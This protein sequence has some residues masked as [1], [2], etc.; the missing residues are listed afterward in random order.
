MR[1]SL[2]LLLRGMRWRLGVSVLTVLTSAVAVGAA[3]LGPL[4]LAT[5]GDSVV[6]TTVHSAP[7]YERG[8]TI[9][10]PPGQSVHLPQLQQAEQRVE[11][12]GGSHRWYGTPITSVISSVEFVIDKSP[13]ASQLLYRSGICG[14]LHFQAGGCKLGFDDVL[15]ST[16]SAREVHA[17]LGSVL[18][19]GVNGSS[20]PLRLRITGIYAVPNLQLPYWWDNGAGYFPY[21][22][23]TGPNHVPEIDSLISS[24]T[25]AL[26]VPVQDVPQVGGQVP[27]RTNAIGLADESQLKHALGSLSNSLS[28]RGLV[29]NTQLSSLFANADHQRHVMSAIVA[30]AAVQLVVLAIWVLASLLVRSADARQSEIRVARLRGFPASTLITATAAE[31]AVL[32]LCGVVLGLVAAWVT[33]VFARAQVLDHAATISADGWMFAALAATLVAIVG[34]L[35]YGTARLMR[36]SSLGQTSV[37]AQTG[38]ARGGPIADIVLLVLSVVALIALATSGALAGHSNPIASAA[39]GLIALGTAVL[40][41]QL[42]LFLCRLG[43]SASLNSDRIAAFLALRQVVRR[44]TVLRQARVLIIALCL[45]CFATSAWAVAR[46]NRRANAMFTV[47]SS[48]VASVTP[49]GVGLQQAVDRVDP[50]GHFAM[51]AVALT[52]AS[53]N[54]LAVDV[55]RLRAALSWPAGISHAT[56]AALARALSPP[57]PP[58]VSLTGSALRVT[59]SISSTRPGAGL[60]DLDLA[61]WVAN[62]QD[63]TSIIDLGQAHAGAFGYGASIAA[64]CPA[65]CQLS[66]LGLVPALGH[67][68]PSSGTFRV[69]V[70]SMS[71]RSASGTEAPIAADLSTNGW[72]S[73]ATGVQVTGS[74]GGGLAFV[75]PAS[76]VAAYA[77]AVGSFISP[78]AS[79]AD[80]PQVLPGAATSELESINPAATTGG[81]IPSQGLDGGTLTVRAAVTTSSIP[82]L[83][84]DALMVNLTLLSHAQVNPT[85]PDATD[86]VWLGPSAPANALARLRAAGLT[87]D[88][89][90]RASSVF[91]ALQRS[92]PALADDFMLVATIVALLAA[93]ASTLGAVGATARQRAT[94]L[95]VLEVSGIRKLVL[96]R[97]LAFESVV[98]AATAL[99]GTAA[100]IVAAVMA[101]PSLPELASPSLVPLQYGLPGVL[102]ALV[103]VAVILTVLV[104]TGVVA[105]FLIRRMSPLLLRTAPNDATG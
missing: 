101:I 68:A 105:L 54:V 33:M 94:E 95:A 91:Q 64:A 18:L 72:R 15:I 17:S 51:A 57:T 67:R 26:A 20:K 6:R 56:I 27:L 79:V 82:R 78:M 24:S 58:A 43:V 93:A 61:A 10:P 96:A 98:L 59:A 52:T 76:E 16:R 44:P 81:V 102:V 1:G 11:N 104:S 50:K 34:T 65:G 45:A 9:S 32:C 23:T 48:E 49:R 29:I 39:P 66:G 47:G 22:Q 60:A 5:A 55:S 30:I 73:S 86:Q 4:Y 90:D 69:T 87:I 37:A 84:D 80:Y 70:T 3:V 21:G 41:L 75:V 63:G 31:P 77:S 2:G 8:A 38:A 92:G 36:S 53:S 28:S 25:T 71:V 83:G 14:Y 100:G 19:A 35:A 7:V 46:D 74:A 85:S 97:S 103:T 62:P 89:V 99:F 42:V 40:A 13:L 88:S 12:L